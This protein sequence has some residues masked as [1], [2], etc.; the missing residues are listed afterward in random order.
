MPDCSEKRSGTKPLRFVV[1]HRI[2]GLEQGPFP[3]QSLVSGPRSSDSIATYHLEKTLAVRRSPTYLSFFRAATLPLRRVGPREKPG[4]EF[5][6]IGHIG[7]SESAICRISK[8]ELDF[9]GKNSFADALGFRTR[10]KCRSM[11][12]GLG[13]IYQGLWGRAR[14]LAHESGWETCQPQ[15]RYR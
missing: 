2:A 13:S 10:P 7:I 9:A 6:P 5:A 8:L 3:R 12:A 15:R 4:V 14:L 11:A 1:L